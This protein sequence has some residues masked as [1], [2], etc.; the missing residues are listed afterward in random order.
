MILGGQQDIFNVLKSVELYNW[1]TGE[2]VTI[3]LNIKYCFPNYKFQYL[4]WR[5]IFRD[6]IDKHISVLR[7]D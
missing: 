2:Q 5:I 4:F 6:K 1:Q 3:I 7:E